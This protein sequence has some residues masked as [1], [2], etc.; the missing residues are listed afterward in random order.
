MPFSLRWSPSFRSTGCTRPSRKLQ[1]TGRKP[2]VHPAVQSP[3]GQRNI[4]CTVESHYGSNEFTIERSSV[5]GGSA[6]LR[7]PSSRKGSFPVGRSGDLHGERGCT[8]VFTVRTE[9]H[10]QRK[11]LCFPKDICRQDDSDLLQMR[12]QARVRY[13]YYAVLD[14]AF[15]EHP[16]R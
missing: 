3:H 9:V 14:R 7:N 10:S 16:V 1:V 6:G 2:C 8:V 4:A 11:Q 12:T 5:R 15:C 13:G